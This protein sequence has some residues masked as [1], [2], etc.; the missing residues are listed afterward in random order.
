M[1]LSGREDIGLAIGDAFAAMTDFGF[2]E[3]QLL[4]RGIDVVRTDPRDGIGAAWAV[5]AAWNGR[6]YPVAV[7]LAD[8]APPGAAVLQARSNG[9]SG[10][11]RA[12]LAALAR[13]QTRIRV[14]LTV[15]GS[16]F[17]DRML[18]NSLALAKTRLSRQ[19]SEAVSAFAR[20]VETRAARA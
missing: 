16:G 18:L 3:R 8:W 4:R 20:S 1:R 11:I 17:R 9:L 5:Q 13:R 14:T 7:A 2:L 12:E 6:A 15:T 19:F 10:E